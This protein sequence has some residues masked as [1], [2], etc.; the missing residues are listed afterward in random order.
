MA[1]EFQVLS[2]LT[3]PEPRITHRVV[4]FRVKDQ[5]FY[6]ILSSVEVVD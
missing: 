6:M 4:I 3:R 5:G 1:A 2:D